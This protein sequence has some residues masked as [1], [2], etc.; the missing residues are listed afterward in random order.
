MSYLNAT[1][2]TSERRIERVREILNQMLVAAIEDCK[3][4]FQCRKGKS[5][6]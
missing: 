6:V 2:H 5:Q 3:L 1:T 4:P